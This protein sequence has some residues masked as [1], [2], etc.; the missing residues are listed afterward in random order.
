M[1]ARGPMGRLRER[2][3]GDRVMS[4]RKRLVL[5]VTGLIAAA[6]LIIGIALP[7][8]MRSFLVDQLDEQLIA[9]STRAERFDGD[10]DGDGAGG[11]P[12]RGQ[13]SPKGLVQPGQ[14]IGTLAAVRSDE[15][16][17][18]AILDKDGE[19]AG[20]SPDAVEQLVE[21]EEPAD[22][23]TM[24]LHEYGH[25]RVMAVQT[26]DGLLITGLPMRGAAETIGRLVIIEIIVA[27]LVLA[28]AA[29]VSAGMIG[30]MLA[31]LRRVA[32]TAKRV[33]DLPLD[34]GDVELA[35]RVAPADADPRTEVGQVG[36][37][38][39]EM[40]GHVERALESRQRSEQRV[41]S[42]VADASHELRTPLAAIR[43]YAELTRRSKDDVPPDI[44]HALDRVESESVR[45]T[46]L[47]EDLLLLARLDSGRPLDRAPVDLAALMIDAVSDAHA[48]G[49]DYEWRLELPDEALE[50]SGDRA[51]L[52]QVLANLLANARTHTPPGTEVVVSLRR[53][54]D[55][56][57][58][59][60][61]V[62]DD[63]PGIA[64]DLLPT[65]FDRFARG[66]S[67]R[68][69]EKG[70]TGLGLAIVAAVTASHGGTVAVESEPGRTEFTVTLPLSAP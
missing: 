26:G 58:A 17:S 64:P 60:I 7:L 56:T 3:A 69:R 27:G 23:V 62:R 51:R 57:Q 67:S 32:G 13:G 46:A 28:V 43:G 38:I 53:S 33:S 39:N 49:P 12:G 16:I 18:C 14:S 15:S 68:S 9:A 19:P 47:V 30:R 20:C 41:R 34:Q 29:I 37:A 70:S 66:D 42:F 1:T 21:I 50:V 24:D 35:E 2:T 22:P 11:G 65:V 48:V 55:G 25:Y 5:S 40:L 8:I 54:D 63:G 6:C 59:V 45:M 61:A 52:H 4:L 36:Y 10:H 44:A 31:P